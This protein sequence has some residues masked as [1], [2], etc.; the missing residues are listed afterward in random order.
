MLRALCVADPSELLGKHYHF[1][2]YST[3]LHAS[4]SMR[5]KLVGIPNLRV[6]GFFCSGRSVS[7]WVYRLSHA[8]LKGAG[9]NTFPEKK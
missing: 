1:R 4:L 3:L 9:T 2:S 8:P 6:Y 7:G 5:L